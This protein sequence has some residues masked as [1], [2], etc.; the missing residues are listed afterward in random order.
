MIVLPIAKMI[1]FHMTKITGTGNLKL[2]NS[3]KKRLG[4][5]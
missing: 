2:Q 5:G 1:F 3:V 4:E